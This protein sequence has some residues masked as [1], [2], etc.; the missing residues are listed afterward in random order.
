MT[1][2]HPV[3]VGALRR[4]AD[5]WPAAVPIAEL[6]GD[7]ESADGRLLMLCEAL[8]GCFAAK[9]LRLHAHPPELCTQPGPRPR[10]SP[11]ARLQARERGWVTT[12]W[13]TNIRLEDDL[14]WRL[15]AL[16]DGTRDRAALLAALKKGMKGGYPQLARDLDR[17]LETLGRAALLLADAARPSCRA[18]RRIRRSKL[19]IRRSPRRSRDQRC[20]CPTSGATEPRLWRGAAQIRTAA[21]EAEK[22]LR[23]DRRRS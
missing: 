5:S 4:I 13:H 10:V 7:G 14:G 8:L 12:L 20:D 16:L 3:L 18:V 2:D 1:T 23:R 15:L 17:S 9:L 11:L 22:S 6:A 21:G 19:D